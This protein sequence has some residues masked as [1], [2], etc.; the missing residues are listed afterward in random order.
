MLNVEFARN[1][2][3]KRSL[4]LTPLI[5]IIFLL[6]VFFLLT[7][8]YVLTEVVDLSI[9]SV[10]SEASEDNDFNN[11]TPILVVLTEGNSFLYSGKEY[12]LSLMGEII[13]GE[14]S[15]NKDRNVIITN[16]E[17][18]SVQELVTAMDGIKSA[19]GY[20]ISIVEGSG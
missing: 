20:N 3:D 6:V 14:I 10:K 18:V 16:R 9:S 15:D 13:G 12:N 5:D 17:G 7:S 4:N 19:G 2:R 1:K 8:E 11:E